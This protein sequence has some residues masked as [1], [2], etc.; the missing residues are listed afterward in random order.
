MKKLILAVSIS[1]L[2]IVT[3]DAVA[4]SG[5][6]ITFSGYVAES[7]CQVDVNGGQY[8]V[9]KLPSL[10]GSA[11]STAVVKD[12]KMSLRGCV[13]GVTTKLVSNVNPNI[14]SSNSVSVD[15]AETSGKNVGNVLS[16]R[17]VSSPDGARRGVA[18]VLAYKQYNINYF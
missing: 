12:V 15:V 7:T 13:T 16:V 3:I 14:S 5:G 4:A 10:T 2:S 11:S 18:Q 17:Y 8:P 6:T 1:A 9:V